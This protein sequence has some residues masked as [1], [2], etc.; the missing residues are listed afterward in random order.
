MIRQKE[1]RKSIETN[2][3]GQTKDKTLKMKMKMN[4]SDKL[5]SEKW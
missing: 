5:D 3:Q 4:I 1:T 2:F